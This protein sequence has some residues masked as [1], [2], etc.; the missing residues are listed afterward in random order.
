MPTSTIAPKLKTSN[1]KGAV[2]NYY[3]TNLS[4]DHL[5]IKQA[6]IVNKCCKVWQLQDRMFMAGKQLIGMPYPELSVCAE[7]M[8]ATRQVCLV[9]T[10]DMFVVHL[11]HN[12][13]Y[14]Y[15]GKTIFITIT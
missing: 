9:L 1:K 5:K 13:Q 14:N 11:L 4:T 15:T 6:Q 10:L 8:E 2:I 3:G 12:Y 7:R